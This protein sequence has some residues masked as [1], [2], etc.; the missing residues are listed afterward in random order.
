MVAERVLHV[1]GHKRCCKSDYPNGPD[2]LESNARMSNGKEWMATASHH[3]DNDQHNRQHPKALEDRQKRVSTRVPISK[4]T[5]D[6][7][8]HENNIKKNTLAKALPIAHAIQ[9]LVLA[10][11]D[12]GIF[13]DGS[14][15]RYARRDML[16]LV[17]GQRQPAPP[18]FSG[19]RSRVGMPNLRASSGPNAPPPLAI[20]AHRRSRL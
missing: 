16:S 3:Q 4:T 17:W 19:Q 2:F 10:S 20:N 7:D 1:C 14:A 12:S 5:D 13:L 11:F 18:R 8:C 9:L 6:V 15:L